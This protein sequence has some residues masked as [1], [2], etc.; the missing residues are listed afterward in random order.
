[1]DLIETFERKLAFSIPVSEKKHFKRHF[2]SS[3]NLKIC[4]RDTLRC[5]SLCCLARDIG[6]EKEFTYLIPILVLSLLNFSHI[7]DIKRINM[8]KQATKAA[9]LK[10]KTTL[11]NLFKNFIVLIE[12]AF[13]DSLL[14]TNNVGVLFYR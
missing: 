6:I 7:S 12:T 3:I 13:V 2:Q 4:S 14:Q 8:A 1:M 9:A 11:S 10:N 5:F